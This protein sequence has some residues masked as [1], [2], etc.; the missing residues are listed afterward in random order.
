[1]DLL[2]V[3]LIVWI[4]CGIGATFVASGRGANGCLWFGLG[5]L[6]GP[7]GL[8]ASFMAGSSTECPSCRKRI[9]P[10]AQRCPHCQTNLAPEV[11][12]R[13]PDAGVV[14]GVTCGACGFRND[15]DWKFCGQCSEPLQRS[16]SK[17]PRL[18]QPIAA[19]PDLT[20]QFER[21][22]EMHSKGVLS[23]EEFRRAK[24]KLLE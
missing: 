1:M 10:E 9:H 4:F 8:A 16:E 23:D 22:A 14:L 12:D 19:S 7:L 13:T 15:A 18:Q 6:F 20:G 11:S 17:T 5:F 3:C 21:L 2:V 24:A